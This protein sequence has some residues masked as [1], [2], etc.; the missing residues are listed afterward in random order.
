MTN[1]CNATVEGNV[2]EL[3]ALLVSQTEEAIFCVECAGHTVVLFNGGAERI[4]DYNAEEILGE[5][6]SAI[7]PVQERKESRVQTIGTRKDGTQFPLELTI[8]TVEMNGKDYCAV[9]ARESEVAKMAELAQYRKTVKQQL[10][11]E[12]DSI[13]DLKLASRT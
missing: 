1:G 4:F 13:A 8:S 9:I 12:M 11:K 5:H 7:V 6:V 2:G 3:L 10:L